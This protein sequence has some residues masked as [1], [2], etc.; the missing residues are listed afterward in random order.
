[1]ADELRE[2]ILA[3]FL[4]RSRMA[5]GPRPGYLLRRRAIEAGVAGAEGQQLDRALE[6]L[7]A[8]GLL[9]RNE[10]ATL[11]FLSEAGVEALTATA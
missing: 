8:E 7:V 4:S 3:R 2:K 5:G 11:Y 9:K 1:M 10:E 6:T